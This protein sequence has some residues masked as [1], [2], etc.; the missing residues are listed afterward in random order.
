MAIIKFQNVGIRAISACVPKTISSNYNLGDLVPEKTVEKLIKSIGIK[1]KRISDKDVCTSDLCYKAAEKLMSDNNVDPSSID[2]LLFV[3]LTP[4]YITP[5]SSSILQ[6]RLSLSTTTACIDISLSCSGFIYALSTAFAYT[7][8]VGVEKVLVLVGE[9]MSKITNRRDRVNYPLFG[10]AGTACLV[11]KG[12]YKESIFLL[13]GDGNGEDVVKITHGSYRNP[14]TKDSLENKERED[15]NYRKDID[16]AMDGMTTFNHAITA[17]PKQIK[18]LM[19]VS[20]ITAND[21]DYL[22][23]HQANRF[24]IDFIIKRLKFDSNKVPFCLEKYGNTSSASIPLTIVSE[25][26]SK[27]RGEKKL[28]FSAIGAGWSYG[29]A[30]ITTKDVNVSSIIEY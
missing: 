23:S 28:L 8:M 20:N 22:V 17:I 18:K 6:K 21:V 11:E 10:D 9:T 24:M 13:E 15:G 12:D 19:N 30:F 14:L 4:D 5:H 27:L 2:M 7:S 29:T 16:F 25:L 3:S 1:E 26:E